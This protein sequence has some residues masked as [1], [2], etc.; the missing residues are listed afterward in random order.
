MAGVEEHSFQVA[1]SHLTHPPEGMVHLG[2][3]RVAAETDEP[4][5]KHFAFKLTNLIGKDLVEF[6]VSVNLSSPLPHSLMTPVRLAGLIQSRVLCPDLD[7]WVRVTDPVVDISLVPALKGL[8]N[9]FD[10]LLPGHR[11]QYCVPAPKQSYS[12]ISRPPNRTATYV[13]S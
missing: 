8:T 12:P 6:E 10:V 13:S 5:H 11:D 4:K 9:D 3:T 2:A 1:L 7:F